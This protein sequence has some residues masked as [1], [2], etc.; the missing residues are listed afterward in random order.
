LWWGHSLRLSP[1]HRPT[2]PA[3][4]DSRERSGCQTHIFADARLGVGALPTSSK[5]GI[6]WAD[7]AGSVAT[8]AE[9]FEMGKVTGAI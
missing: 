5:L 6:V 7:V 2:T 8:V 4:S 3:C 9:L 1:P